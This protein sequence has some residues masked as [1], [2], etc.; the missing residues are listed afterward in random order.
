MGIDN[1]IYPLATLLVVSAL[2]EA[3]VEML[4]SIV[5]KPFSES[6]KRILALLISVFL[7]LV[8]KV[9]LFNITGPAYYV[10][11]LLAGLIASRGSN[12]IHEFAKILEA[13]PLKKR[14]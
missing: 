4:K 10:G 11:V 13:I 1:I 12:F 7:S 14:K 2:T 3:V 6:G 8:L 5:P 9:S